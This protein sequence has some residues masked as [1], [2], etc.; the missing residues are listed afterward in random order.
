MTPKVYS[1][2]VNLG[3]GIGIG[4]DIANAITLTSKVYGPPT[5]QSS[6]LG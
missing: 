2:F 4:T 5:Q 1:S 3:I 6:D